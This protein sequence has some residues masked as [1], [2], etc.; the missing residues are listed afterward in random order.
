MIKSRVQEF[1]GLCQKGE[2]G[3]NFFDDR[4]DTTKDDRLI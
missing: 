1:D 4:E 3:Y 2:I